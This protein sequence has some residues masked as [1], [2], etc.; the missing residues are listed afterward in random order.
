MRC[1]NCPHVFHHP[2]AG[3]CLAAVLTGPLCPCPGYEAEEETTQEEWTREKQ[4]CNP[5][6]GYVRP[7]K[8]KE[9]KAEV[10]VEQWLCNVGQLM[11]GW[12]ADGT[13]WS[14]WDESLRAQL[15]AVRR[16]VATP[17]PPSPRAAVYAAAD[18]LVEHLRAEERWEC[19]LSWDNE[20]KRLTD[21][22]VAAAV[23]A[24]AKETKS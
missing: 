22:L 9:E 24:A 16:A 13:A 23:E 14:E 3:F 1:K 8:V 12:H 7:R 4:D 10:D 5:T 20:R 2:E 19:G 15:P 21:A 6:H 11:D 17:A 18:A